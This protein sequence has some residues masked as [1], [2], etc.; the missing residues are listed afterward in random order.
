MQQQL[1]NHSSVSSANLCSVKNQLVFLACSKK[2]NHSKTQ[3]AESLIWLA[4]CTSSH[5]NAASVK[6][7]NCSHVGSATG[8]SVLPLILNKVST[9]WIWLSKV[10]LHVP[11]KKHA[12][13]PIEASMIIHMPKFKHMFKCPAELLMKGDFHLSWTMLHG[14]PL[15]NSRSWEEMEGKGDT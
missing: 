11:N 7:I 10:V 12:S 3:E 6:Q 14:L 8:A 9:F 13:H 5:S 4:D 2:K 15:S 1:A